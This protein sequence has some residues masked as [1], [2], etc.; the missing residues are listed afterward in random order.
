MRVPPPPLASGKPARG[1]AHLDQ[2]L[3]KI[4]SLG[5]AFHDCFGRHCR[6]AGI[7]L[8]VVLLLATCLAIGHGQSSIYQVFSLSLGMI[9]IGA[10]WAFSRSAVLEAK[11]ELPRFATAGVAF[12]YTVQVSQRGMVGYR[13]LGSSTPRRILDQVWRHFLSSG[14]P[15][16]TSEIVLIATLPIFAGA[17]YSKEIATSP[18]DNPAPTSTC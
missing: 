10:L 11:R 14:N 15:V 4:Y 6:P 9:L 16:K 3:H 12:T 2:R 7:A 8:G 18:V 17:G 5:A 13:V 1:R